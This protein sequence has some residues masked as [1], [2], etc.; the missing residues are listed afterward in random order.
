MRAIGPLF[1]RGRWF[2]AHALQDIGEELGTLK[3]ALD[4]WGD[5]REQKGDWERIASKSG[6]IAEY[7]EWKESEFPKLMETIKKQM[8][9]YYAPQTEAA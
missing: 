3:Y 7:M 1:A 6:Q 8:S 4:G 5:L 9:E 2:F